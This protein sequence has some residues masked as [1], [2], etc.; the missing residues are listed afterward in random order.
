[1]VKVP[2][3]ASNFGAFKYVIQHNQTGLL[4]TNITDWYL[5]LKILI[6]KENLRKNLG[7]NAYKFCKKNYNTIQTGIKLVNYINSFSNKHIGFFLP[8][9]K[10]FGGIYV[11]LKHA[12]ILQDEGWDVDL[13]LPDV[14][15]ELYEFQNHT[16]NLINLKNHIINAQY[17]I[18]VATLYSTIYS[19]LGYYKTKKHVYL[20]QGYETDFYSYFSFF[21]GVAEKTFSAPFNIEYITI[22]KWCQSWLNKKYK[23]IAKYAPN[24]I[25]LN[26]YLSHKRN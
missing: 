23:K 2:T 5:S 25:D 26:N 14:D 24:G 21:R 16:F 22:S 20:V 4:C 18:I 13:I 12:C 15:K 1:M 10:I 7:E 19:I 6:E 17:D 3:I 9:I 11:V 8:F